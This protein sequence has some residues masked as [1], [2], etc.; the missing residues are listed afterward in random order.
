M[1]Y[2]INNMFAKKL[3][4]PKISLRLFNNFLSFVVAGLALYIIA[5][6]FLPQFD[7]WLKH[8]SPIQSVIH[9]KKPSP[10]AMPPSEQLV[11]GDMLFMPNLEMQEAV[12]GG[13]KAS[14]SRGVWRVPHTSTPDKGGNTVL[15]GHRFT[16]KTRMG[17]FYHLDKVKKDDPITIHWQ[18]KVYEYRVVE[19]KVVPATEVSVEDN[20]TEPRL[21]IYT[22][23]PLWSVSHRLVIIAEPVEGAL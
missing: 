8:D 20:T 16:Y 12:Y 11:Q 19:T 2:T 13:G 4:L 7:W 21:T 9:N 6:P 3:R 15:V 17:V 23:T 14:L 22:C 10:A 5:V 18:G 1:A